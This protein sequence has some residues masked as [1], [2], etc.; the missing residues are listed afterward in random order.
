MAME[1][2]ISLVAVAL[3][4]AVALGPVA[5]A[6]QDEDDMRPMIDRLDRLERDVNLLQR[7]LVYRNSSAGLATVPTQSAAVPQGTAIDVEVRLGR[8]EEQMRTLTGQIEDTTYKL[9]QVSQ[10][11]DKMQTDMDFRLGQLEHPGS[12]P[13]TAASTAPVLPPPPAR[14][15]TPTPTADAYGAGPIR[16]RPPGGGGGGDTAPS[17]GQSGVLGT[18]VVPSDAADTGGTTP[19]QVA[20]APTTTTPQNVQGSPL[21]QYNAAFAL[22]RGARY[23]EAELALRAFVQRNPKDALAGAAQYWLGEVYYVRKD[24]P[25]AAQ[26]FA[27][28]YETYPKSSKAPDTLLKLAMTLGVLGQKDNACRAYARLDHDFPQ[29]QADIRDRATAE[30][31]RLACP[32]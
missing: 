19:G 24:Y 18:I 26:A 9:Q 22:V 13:S 11:L 1:R 2:L 3:L 29:A 30:K 27:A 10:R 15:T 25:N 21:E 20:A 17:A 14:I 5:Y 16:L 32:A 12:A 7:Q 23:D 28:G 6:Q 8:L 4:A 31:K